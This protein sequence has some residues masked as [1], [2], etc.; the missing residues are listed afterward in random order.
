[1]VNCRD[2]KVDETYLKF[3]DI[4]YHCDHLESKQKQWRERE[5]RGVERGSRILLLCNELINE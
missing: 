1:M 4:M 2:Y 3:N 5:R